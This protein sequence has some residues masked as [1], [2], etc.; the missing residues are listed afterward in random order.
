MACVMACCRASDWISSRRADRRC[1][2]LGGA[3]SHADAPRCCLRWPRNS[4]G[5]LPHHLC[6][7]IIVNA[8]ACMPA[9]LRACVRAQTFWR[10]GLKG[11]RGIEPFF[12]TDAKLQLLTHNAKHDYA[13][14]PSSTAAFIWVAFTHANGVDGTKAVLCDPV[15]L[16]PARCQSVVGELGLACRLAHRAQPCAALCCACCTQL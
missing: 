4:A 7:A 3:R 5:L 15:A 1:S 9:P 10:T 2:R 6:R 12:S 11:A 13:R 8:A 14:A 16:N